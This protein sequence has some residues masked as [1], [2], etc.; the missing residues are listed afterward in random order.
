VLPAAKLPAVRKD[1][2][3]GPLLAVSRAANAITIARGPLVVDW[4]DTSPLASRERFAA[5][6]YVAA[7]LVEAL[8]ASETLSKHYKG[9]QQFDEGFGRLLSDASVS[10][11]RSKTLKRFRDKGTFHFDG[12]FFRAAATQLPTEE[13]ILATIQS[14]Q[15]QDIYLNVPDDLL[16]A[17]I[18]GP[19]PNDES[20]ASVFEEFATTT[21]SVMNQFLESAHRLIPVALLRLGAI[22]RRAV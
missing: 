4:K 9:V 7:V 22:K 18:L 11:F 1:P 3:F 16:F 13:I 12:G 6:F 17:H 10:T 8:K 14:N 19:F 21:V 15:I 20:M 5:L 2:C